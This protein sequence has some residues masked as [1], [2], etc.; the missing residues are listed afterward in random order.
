MTPNPD[1]VSL[2]DAPPELVLPLEPVLDTTPAVAGEVSEI[3]SLTLGERLIV[4]LSAFVS[5]LADRSHM[6]DGPSFF[7]TD[8]ISTRCAS[9]RREAQ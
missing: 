7:E 8:R 4:S 6:G 3:E 2:P 5:T 1:S 9:F